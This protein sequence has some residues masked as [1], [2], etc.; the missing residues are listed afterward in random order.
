MFDVRQLGVSLFVVVAAMLIAAAPALAD[1]DIGET[2]V[3]GAHSLIDTLD[4][5]GATCTYKDKNVSGVPFVLAKVKA[6]PP[7]VLARNVTSFEGDEQLVGWRFTVEK[8]VT[9]NSDG[10][11]TPIVKSS[12][13]K[14]TATE[15]GAAPFTAMKVRVPVPTE[16]ARYRVKVKLFWYRFGSTEGTSTHLVDFYKAVTPDRTFVFEPPFACADGSGN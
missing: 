1:T 15:S 16:A 6:R 7:Q 12:I 4:K 13:Q 9:F 8:Q 14:A 10:S 11:W 3:V 2:G 5:P